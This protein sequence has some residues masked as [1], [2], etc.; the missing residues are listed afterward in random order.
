M[1]G[2]AAILG[3]CTA[4]ASTQAWVQTPAG[5]YAEAPQSAPMAAFDL[6]HPQ[7][8]MWTDWRELCSRTG[9]NGATYCRL[10]P[11]HPA[12]PSEPFCAANAVVP[13]TPE[14]QASRDR[15]C[16]EKT[17]IGRCH[18]YKPDRPFGGETLGQMLHPSCRR[19][20]DGTFRNICSNAPNDRLPSCDAENMREARLPKAGPFSDPFSCTL[21]IDPK[22]CAGPIGGRKAAE[23]APNGVVIYDAMDRNRAP[24]GEHFAAHTGDS[25]WYNELQL[26][27]RNMEKI[28]ARISVFRAQA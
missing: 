27:D 3:L 24:Y 17:K 7:C 4:M 11:S 12:R 28:L 10:D 19:W 22:P 8:D 9:P 26:L 15:F 2:L 16:V 1:R 18:T 25:L 21:W 20:G 5:G 14:Q 23:P 13:Y 6:A